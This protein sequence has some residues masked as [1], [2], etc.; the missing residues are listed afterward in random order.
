MYCNTTTDLQRV[1]ANIEDYQYERVVEDWT[2]HSGSAYRKHGTGFVSSVYEDGVQLTSESSVANVIANAGTW[3]YDDDVDM[4]YVHMSGSDDPDDHRI[5]NG[6]DWDTVKT[7]LRNKAQQMVD[8]VLGIKFDVPLLARSKKLHDDSDYEYPIVA[9]TAYLT[10]YLII[11][12][13]NPDDSLAL[14]MYEKAMGSGETKGILMQLLD[15]DIVLQ[16]QAIIRK[17]GGWNIYPGD[18]NSVT[19]SPIFTGQ[20]YGSDRRRWRIEIDTAGA[21]GTATYKV[22]YDGGDT[23]DLELEDTK[24]EE[25]IRFYITD[26]VWVEWPEVSYSVGDY[27]D[28]DLYPMTDEASNAKI[29]T[30]ELTL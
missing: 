11:S 5:T 15:G 7:A 9:A 25:T 12:R 30:I 24:D 14:T 17:S 19:V 18:N 21:I 28:V 29:S 22:S 4:L 16:D 20:Y 6:E 3:Y 8:S 10:C 23:W 1:C 27:W 2:L 13:V 26:G